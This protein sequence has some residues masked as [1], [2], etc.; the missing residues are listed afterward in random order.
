MAD[1]PIA[2]SGVAVGGPPVVLAHSTY[3]RHA[4]AVRY[5]EGLS[6]TPTPWSGRQVHPRGA[7]GGTLRKA[8]TGSGG[9]PA[10]VHDYEPTGAT[11]H[12]CRWTGTRWTPTDDYVTAYNPSPAAAV[13][14]L[15]YVT[16][17]RVGPIWEVVV[18]PCTSAYYY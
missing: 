3:Q 10:A 4:A 7:G 15:T 6:R 13:A 1:Q 9:I 8:M 11:V 18:E 14:A 16:I 2:P 17:A 12:L 5:V